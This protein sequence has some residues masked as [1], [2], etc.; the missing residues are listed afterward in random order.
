[1]GI[2]A[3]DYMDLSSMTITEIDKSTSYLSHGGP[4]KEHKYIKKIGG[5]YYYEEKL[6][7]NY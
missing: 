1:L 7:R 6:K 4:W 2:K 5:R 3:G